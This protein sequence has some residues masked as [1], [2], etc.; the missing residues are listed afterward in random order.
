MIT[1][2]ININNNPFGKLNFLG[3]LASLDFPTTRLFTDNNNELIVVEWADELEDSSD[4][5]YMYK[6]LPQDFKLFLKKQISHL[7]LIMKSRN[8]TL[9]LFQGDLNKANNFY[10]LGNSSIDIDFLPDGDIYFD[11]EDCPDYTVIDNYVSTYLSNIQIELDDKYDQKKVLQNVAK[12]YGSEVIN[13][14]ANSGKHVDFGKIDTATLGEMLSSFQNLYS[15]VTTDR[16]MGKDRAN[17]LKKAQKFELE[18]MKQTEVLVSHAASFSL[19]IKPKT[20]YYEF[21]IELHDEIDSQVIESSEVILH[22]IHKLISESQTTESL[23]NISGKYSY[24]TFDK[25]HKFAQQIKKFELNLDL[26][27]FSP[28]SQRYIEYSFVDNTADYIVTNLESFKIVDDDKLTNKGK[29][30]AINCKTFHFTF[31]SF[32]DTEYSGYFDSLIKDSAPTLNFVDVYDIIIMQI[33]TKTLHH[34]EA[35]IENT[36][37]SVLKIEV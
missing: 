7:Q 16:Y 5:F 28:T 30:I 29:F 33:E 24:Q 20:T 11:E 27:F 36:L 17:K 15:E 2:G 22:D 8:N 1:K 37:I 13:L 31:K 14:H 6:I 12:E 32:D 19:F 4:L 34:S 35:K 21:N 3:I 10:I 9:V 18:K 23:G 25:L 26:N